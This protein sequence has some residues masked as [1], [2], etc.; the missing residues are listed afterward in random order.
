MKLIP[1]FPSEIL[2]EI[3]VIYSLSPATAIPAILL[4]KT[5][6]DVTVTLDESIMLIQYFESLMVDSLILIFCESLTRIPLAT[7]EMLT[8]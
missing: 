1:I 7:F 8:F 3:I 2:L 5:L 4:L 6:F